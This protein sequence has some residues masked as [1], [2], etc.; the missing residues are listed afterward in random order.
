MVTRPVAG[1]EPG[2]CSSQPMLNLESAL[3]LLS[4]GGAPPRC[5]SVPGWSVCVHHRP[6][7][8]RAGPPLVFQAG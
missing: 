8:G 2:D 1:R 6:A 5:R 7:S 4:T 3:E